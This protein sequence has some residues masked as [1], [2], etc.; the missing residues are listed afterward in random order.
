VRRRRCFGVE[1]VMTKTVEPGQIRRSRA[2]NYK[3]N[4]RPSKEEDK[5]ER[6]KTKSILKGGKNGGRESEK[7]AGC[8]WESGMKEKEGR[9]NLGGMRDIGGWS[10]G[11]SGGGSSGSGGGGGGGGSEMGASE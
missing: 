11:S 7:R 2:Q 5:G 9:L 1:G 6:R 3:K 8:W 10:G 4:R